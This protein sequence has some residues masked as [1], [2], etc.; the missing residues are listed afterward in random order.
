VTSQDQ[1]AQYPVWQRDV[2]PARPAS[3]RKPSALRQALLT[4]LEE[5]RFRSGVTMLVAAAGVLALGGG[6]LGLA[7]QG[8]AGAPGPETVRPA[9]GSSSS[10]SIARTPVSA[11]PT[12]G[13]RV[14]PTTPAQAAPPPRSAGAPPS[15]KPTPR[16]T[17]RPDRVDRRHRF[18]D[19]RDRDR[20][21]RRWRDRSWWRHR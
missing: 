13:E 14:P 5:I 12:R 3:H 8:G 15:L 4:R 21:D 11:D 7:L 2:T 9:T 6:G 17:Q 1:T 19:R 10:P 16:A 18:D 20:S